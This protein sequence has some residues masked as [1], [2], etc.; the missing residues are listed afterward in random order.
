MLALAREG[1]KVAFV[2]HGNQDAA[3]KLEEEVA[4]AGGVAKGVQGDVADPD[5]GRAAG[6]S[7][8]LA[9]HGRL[10]ILVNNAGVIRDELFVRMEAADWNA[11]I[12]TN[13]NGT[14]ASAR[15]WPSRWR[16]SSG[17]GGS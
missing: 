4:A 14:F 17:T 6:R 1:A 11:V 2:Y 3:T 16:S 10:D 12:D 8:V 5:R 9:E 15:R 13:L 7:G